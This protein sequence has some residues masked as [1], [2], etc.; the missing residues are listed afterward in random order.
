MYYNISTHKTYF[1]YD[2][3]DISDA[4]TNN[5]NKSDGYWNYLNRVFATK[6]LL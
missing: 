4:V 5:A 2:L 3:Q 6:E 1:M